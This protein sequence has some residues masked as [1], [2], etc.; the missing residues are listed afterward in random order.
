MAKHGQRRKGGRKN[1]NEKRT[2]PDPETRAYTKPAKQARKDASASHYARKKCVAEQS[3][4]KGLQDTVANHSGRPRT[5]HENSVWLCMF[6]TVFMSQLEAA[7]LQVV[8]EPPA[9]HTLA[10]KMADQARMN[11]QNALDLV[12]NFFADGSVLVSGREAHGPG[13]PGC[14]ENAHRLSSAQLKTIDNFIDEKHAAG[15]TVSV[16]Q[17]RAQLRREHPGVIISEG[18]VRYAMLHFCNNGDGYHWGKVKPRKCQSDPERIDV[19]RT[20]LKEYFEA[21]RKERAGTHVCVYLDESYIHQW[22]ASNF[23]WCK[24]SPDGNHIGRGASTGK[25]LIM[26]HALTKD[27]PLVTRYPAGDTDADGNDRGGQPIVDFEWGRGAKKDIC[28]TQAAGLTCELLWTASQ[29]SGDYHGE[30]ALPCSININCNIF[31]LWICGVAL[32]CSLQLT[33]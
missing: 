21:L 24:N 29:H 26:L 10:R 2:G 32:A 25:R 1:A 12:D 33:H 16:P 20:F 31:H 27:G 11:P 23:S 13:S 19:K 15:I 5:Y 28:T 17:I 9:P 6:C 7:A 30:P 14:I 4:V 18:A 8:C 3:R 22:H